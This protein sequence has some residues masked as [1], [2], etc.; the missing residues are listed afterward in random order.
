MLAMPE[1]HYIKHLGE[2]EDMSI[3]EI[4]RKMGRNW[5]TVKK[6]GDGS[7]SEPVLI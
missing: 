6:Y 3:S 7:G 5:R 2:N 1:V 4:A